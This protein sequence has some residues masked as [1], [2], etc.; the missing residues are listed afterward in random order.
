MVDVSPAVRVDGLAEQ[1]T[2]GGSNAFTANAAE[3]LAI[4]RGFGPSL[5][6]P[7]TV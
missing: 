5:T 2:V 1:L 7:A 4:S 6:V 3:Q